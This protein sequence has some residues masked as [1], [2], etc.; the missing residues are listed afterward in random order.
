MA[1][2]TNLNRAGEYVIQPG[3]IKAFHP[4]RLPFVPP[5]EYYEELRFILSMADQ[6][7]GRLDSSAEM[8]PNP[9]LFVGMYVWKE[10]VLSS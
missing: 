4:A 3:G 1:A 5:V 7:I 6:A 8:I 2:H 9:D 10:A